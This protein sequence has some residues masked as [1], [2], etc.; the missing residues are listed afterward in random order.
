MLEIHLYMKNEKTTKNILNSYYHTWQKIQELL[1]S[2]KQYIQILHTY[3]TSV[4]ATSLLLSGCRIFVHMLDGKI[5]EIKLGENECTDR[6]I[7]VS[8]NLEKLL[9]ANE[10]G[11]AIERKYYV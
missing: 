10:F 1:E 9:L 3:Q 7:K 11:L 8:H 2:K 5:V 4:C 6:F